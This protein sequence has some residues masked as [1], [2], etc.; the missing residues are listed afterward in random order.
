METTKTFYAW[1]YRVTVRLE[2][3][4]AEPIAQNGQYF[5]KFKKPVFS[6]SADIYNKGQ[7]YAGGQCREEI[8]ALRET[9][10]NKDLLRPQIKRAWTTY[11]LNDLHA[12]TPRQEQRLKNNNIKGRAN[13]YET[14][15]KTLKKHHL[16]KDHGREFGRGWNYWPIPSGD[17]A[18]IIL[19]IKEIDEQK[20]N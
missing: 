3:K 6:C 13:N 10:L 5:P 17:L 14:I 20:A 7:F 2:L 15:C 18:K 19:M 12:G 9:Y 16:F 1:P 11:H 8:D 4:D